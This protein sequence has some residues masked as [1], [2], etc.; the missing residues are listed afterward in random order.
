MGKQKPRLCTTPG[1]IK[2]RQQKGLCIACGGR[3]CIIC[4]LHGTVFANKCKKCF[5]LTNL[6][7]THIL[8][9]N[10]DQ[11]DGTTTPITTKMIK[12]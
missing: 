4:G 2:Y 8:V 1:C 10:Y 7:P 3:R 6:L 11:I 5:H 9:H 12:L